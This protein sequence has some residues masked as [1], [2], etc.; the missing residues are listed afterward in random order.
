MKK[1][2]FFAF[3]LAVSLAAAGCGGDE[4]G[5]CPGTVCSNCAAGG[6]C[7]IS[8]SPG[9]QQFCG[10]FGFFEDPN[11]RCAYCDTP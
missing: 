9:Q 1:T 10:H 4:F 7:N 2:A 8:C 3:L 11:L 5:S 6:D